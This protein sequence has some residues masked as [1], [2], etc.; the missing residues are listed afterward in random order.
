MILEMSDCDTKLLQVKKLT[1][2]ECK[3]Q[4]TNKSY[5]TFNH[6]VLQ[7]HMNDLRSPGM[8]DLITQ[9]FEDLFDDG[10][11]EDSVQLVQVEGSEY[12]EA[13]L[14]RTSMLKDEASTTMPPKPTPAP[15]KTKF[16]NPP[17]PKTKVP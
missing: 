2:L 4:C 1:M 5:V 16:N 12:M 6:K 17:T 13:V 7:Q 15:K 9:T 14:N 11:P 8:Q 10:E 3:D